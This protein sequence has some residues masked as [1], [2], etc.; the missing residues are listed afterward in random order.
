VQIESKTKSSKLDFAVFPNRNIK[1]V[2]V[3]KI[4]PPPQK[5]QKRAETAASARLF[6]LQK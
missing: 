6:I 2:K 3:L 1:V 5:K 4:L